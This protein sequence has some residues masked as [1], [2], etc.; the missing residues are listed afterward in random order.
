L[1]PT[2]STTLLSAQEAKERMREIV[3]GFFVRRL[4]TEDGKR[5]GR[6]LALETPHLRQNGPA[7]QANAP[8]RGR[9]PRKF[10]TAV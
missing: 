9:N 2:A 4:R 3:E 1:P 10:H 6:L 7:P 8:K 5:V